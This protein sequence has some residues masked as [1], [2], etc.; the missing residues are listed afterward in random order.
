MGPGFFVVLFADNVVVFNIDNLMNYVIAN[1]KYK[2]CALF[3]TLLEYST[4][5]DF[6]RD[7]VF[8]AVHV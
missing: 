7:G 1:K 4:T 5:Q 3:W 8:R 6:I 2:D